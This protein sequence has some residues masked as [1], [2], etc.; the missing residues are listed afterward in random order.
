MSIAIALFMYELLII[1]IKLSLGGVGASG[2]SILFKMGESLDILLQCPKKLN[3]NKVNV[4]NILN[5]S[6]N[7]SAISVKHSCV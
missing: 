6:T 2:R 7:C 4:L 1:W 5:I 3:A